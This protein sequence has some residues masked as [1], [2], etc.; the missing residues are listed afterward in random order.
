MVHS[1]RIWQAQPLKNTLLFDVVGMYH[2]THVSTKPYYLSPM[3]CL[4][5]FSGCQRNG[6]SHIAKSW[7]LSECEVGDGQ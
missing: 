3:A 2:T 1:T 4:L 5:L 6:S 7:R